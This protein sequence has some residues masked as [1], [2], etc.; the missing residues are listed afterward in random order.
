M[1]IS[2]KKSCAD[3][4]LCGSFIYQF[5]W[6]PVHY[7][8]IVIVLFVNF[9]TTG[10]VSHGFCPFRRLPAGPESIYSGGSK[11]CEYFFTSHISSKHSGPKMHFSVRQIGRKLTL[12]VC[13]LQQHTLAKSGDP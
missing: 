13:L 8:L 7:S 4:R 1:I 11:Y 6:L 2:C 3:V 5:I 9:C 10:T 12:F